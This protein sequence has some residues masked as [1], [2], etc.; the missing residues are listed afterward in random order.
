MIAEERGVLAAW[1]RFWP[2]LTGQWKQYLAYVVARFVLG[3]AGSILVGILVVVGLIVLAIPTGILGVGGVAAADAAGPIGWVVVGFAVV[4][5]VIAAILLAL[6][7]SVP[8]QTYLR[9]Y[10]LC[11]LGDTNE[12]F[13]VIAER[14][15]VAG[16]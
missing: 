10:E 16:E 11:V 8:V 4:A 6:V 13:D 5:F 15:R 2:T 7:V 12:A 3:V 14:R 9:Y 1:R